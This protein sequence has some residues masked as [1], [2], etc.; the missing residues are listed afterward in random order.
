MGL[1]SKFAASQALGL[2]QPPQGYPPPVAPQ[3]QSSAFGGQQQQQQ[4]QQPQQPPYVHQQAYAPQQRPSGQQP[5]YQLY[6]PQQHPQQQQYPQQQY[7][8]QQPQQPLQSYGQ[9]PQINQPNYPQQQLPQQQQQQWAPYPINPGSSLQPPPS[10]KPSFATDPEL[11]F[12]ILKETVVE[13]NLQQQYTDETLRR[14]ASEIGRTDPVNAICRSWNIPLEIAFDLVKLSL[15]D[16]VFLMDDSGSIEHSKLQG[17]LKSLLKSTAY[18]SSLFD[19]DGFSV[20]FM[21]SDLEADN[22]RN[23]AQAEDLVDRVQFWGATP[24]VGSLEKLLRRQVGP[25]DQV[26]TVKKPVLV[27]IITDGMPTDSPGQEFQKLITAYKSKPVSFQIAQVGID[28]GAQDFLASLDSDP[29]V[30]GLIDCTSNFE[31]ESAEFKRMTGAHLTRELWYTK[32][33]L[34]SID[35]SYDR[36]D[37]RVQQPLA[38]LKDSGPQYPAHSQPQ[39]P[40]QPQPQQQS[41]PQSQAPYNHNSNNNRNSNSNL[42]PAPRYNLMFNSLSNSLSSPNPHKAINS[43]HL[44]MVVTWH[45]NNRHTNNRHSNRLQLVVTFGNPGYSGPPY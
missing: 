29:I 4:Q 42:R 10:P 8:Q 23:G 30:G 31:M 34:G 6:Q 3:G 44:Q 37:E 24:L 39:Y 43:C 27:I 7:P 19:Q 33:L 13:N 18:A 35:K 32:L 11:L 20:R 28:Q 22:I 14:V 36:R 12:S 17:E 41:Q 9:T 15:Y 1:A 26:T 38:P 25:A 21:N 16:I 2:Q 5:Q 45:I 40:I